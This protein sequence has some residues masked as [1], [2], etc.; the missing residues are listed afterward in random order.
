LTIFVDALDECDQ[1]QATGMVCFFE[2][3]CGVARQS[4]VQL[5]ICFSSRHYPTIIIQKGVEVILEAEIGHKDD[6][7]RYIRSRLR[8]GKSKSADTLRSEILAKSSHIFLW[9]VLVLDILNSEYPSGNISTKGMLERLK[10][11]PPELNKLF[12]MILTRDR[13]NLERLQLCLKWVLFASRPLEPQELYFAVHFGLN[14][15]CSTAWDQQDVELDQMKIF[16]RSSS[17]V[18][19]EVTRNKAAEVQF[20]HESVRDFLLGE[21]GVEWCG[22]TATSWAVATKT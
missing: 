11:I 10:E 13:E 19:V 8:L 2:E 22:Y 12:E 7:E 15:E 16:V 3:L 9:V 14:K 6:I 21:H 18:L 5:Q 20:I 1:R 4:R 17:K